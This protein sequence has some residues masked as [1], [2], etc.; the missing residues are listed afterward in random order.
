MKFQKR[1]VIVEA[2][3]LTAEL[4]QD[5]SLW[6]EWARKALDKDPG[7][8]G[9][10]WYD[11]RS[12]SFLCGTI[13]GIFFIFRGDWIVKNPDGGIIPCDPDLFF[14]QYSLSLGTNDA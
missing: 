7:S 14:E 12:F 13:D 5:H 10:I 3:Q 8:E 11:P 6:P 2:F 9:A 1:P 4:C